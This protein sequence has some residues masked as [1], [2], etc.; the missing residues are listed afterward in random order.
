VS[1]SRIVIRG[2]AAV[3]HDDEPVTAPEV[4]QTLDGLTY[5][6]ETFTDFLGGSEE[7]DVLAAL[8]SGGI[9]RLG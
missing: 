1:R 3:Y 4:L 9:L 2:W 7:E 5:D 6:D 8:E